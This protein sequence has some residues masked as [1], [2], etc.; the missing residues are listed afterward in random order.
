M[1]EV[2]QAIFKLNTIIYELESVS[3]ILSNTNKFQG[4]NTELCSC[5]IDNEIEKLKKA[6]NSLLSIDINKVKE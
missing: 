6:K 2:S 5:V 3:G 4:I 1:D